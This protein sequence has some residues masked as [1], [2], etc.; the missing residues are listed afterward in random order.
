VIRAEGI[1]RRRGQFAIDICSLEDP[2]TQV[3]NNYPKAQPSSVITS[4]IAFAPAIGGG[5]DGTKSAFFCD[6]PL[7]IHSPSSS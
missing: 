6:P 5:H 2:V 3:I 7:R 4:S 1:F